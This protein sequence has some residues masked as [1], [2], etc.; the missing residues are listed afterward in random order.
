MF[1]KP[2]R[3]CA[4]SFFSL[5]SVC[6][7]VNHFCQRASALAH[8]PHGDAVPALR[9]RAAWPND[10][11][12]TLAASRPTRPPG[13]CAHQRQPQVQFQP[14]EHE[15]QPPQVLGGHRF[16]FGFRQ[17]RHHVHVVSSLV[18]AYFSAE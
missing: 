8:R 4:K 7:A 14:A 11:C 10:S 3:P 17:N 1:W 16:E 12:S 9:T 18:T 5:H 2:Q 15:Q 13:G 6:A